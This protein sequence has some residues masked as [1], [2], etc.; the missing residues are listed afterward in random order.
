MRKSG[1]VNRIDSVH[2][3]GDM[4]MERKPLSLSVDSSNAVWLESKFD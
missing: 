3:H 2:F 1:A 4:P